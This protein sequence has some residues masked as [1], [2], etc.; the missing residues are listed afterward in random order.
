[1]RSAQEV[2]LTEA[3]FTKTEINKTFSS[4]YEVCL[5]GIGTETVFTKVGWLYFTASQPLG[6][7]NVEY[8]FV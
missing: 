2:I 1:M 6:C 7:F 4:K 5:K 8:I 3:V